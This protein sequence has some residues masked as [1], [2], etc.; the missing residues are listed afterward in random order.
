MCLRFRFLPLATREAYT[1]CSR[2]IGFY[3]VLF[4]LVYL[5]QASESSQCLADLLREVQT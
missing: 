1:P 5:F 2:L 4:V 3:T